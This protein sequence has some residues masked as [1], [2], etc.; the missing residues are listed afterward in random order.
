MQ[1]TLPKGTRVEVLYPDNC[2]KR[3]WLPATI[4]GRCFNPQAV[5]VLIDGRRNRVNIF[6]GNV[7]M[8]ATAAPA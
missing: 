5:R 2:G 7:R 3:H 6:R 1:H 4:S 8:I